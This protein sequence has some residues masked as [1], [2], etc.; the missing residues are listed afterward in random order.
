MRPSKAFI[1][2][3]KNF[4]TAS[5]GHSSLIT[6]CKKLLYASTCIRDTPSRDTH[7][8]P[9][10]VEGE[11]EVRIYIRTC[12]LTTRFS[13]YISDRTRVREYILTSTP[14]GQA[15][16]KYNC[17]ESFILWLPKI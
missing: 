3:G 15:Y 9:V 16:G 1:N 11:V 6:Y 14:C 13:R 5:A 8:L 2:G 7:P 10:W 12:V 4:M 17:P